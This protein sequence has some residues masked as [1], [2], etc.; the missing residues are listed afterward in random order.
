MPAEREYVF[1]KTIQPFCERIYKY[2]YICVCVCVFVPRIGFIDATRKWNAT[3]PS[4]NRP[5]E[6]ELE[7]YPFAARLCKSSEEM[8]DAKVAPLAVRVILNDKKL[9]C[10]E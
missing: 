1:A 5:W 3:L 2:L 6:I 7:R 10:F 9:N 4:F 8:K